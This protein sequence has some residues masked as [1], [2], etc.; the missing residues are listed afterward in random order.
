MFLYETLMDWS[1]QDQQAAAP[2][3]LA[4][5]RRP[6]LAGPDAS[7]GSAAPLSGAVAVV[8]ALTSDTA[9]SQAPQPR[10]P[11]RRPAQGRDRCFFGDAS[12]G[13]DPSQRRPTPAGQHAARLVARSSGSDSGSARSVARRPR[14]S[15]SPT[16]RVGGHGANFR[17][18]R[19]S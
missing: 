11:L 6:P 1:G 8:L 18:S 19:L 10:R 13:R 5:H 16:S 14:L 15:P 4:A 3:L 12:P 7:S 2:G 17:H 9:S